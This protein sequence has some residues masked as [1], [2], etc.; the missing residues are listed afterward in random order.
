MAK[1]LRLLEPVLPSGLKLPKVMLSVSTLKSLKP[2]GSDL[3]AID[4]Q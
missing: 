1:A 4:A 3:T 2:D